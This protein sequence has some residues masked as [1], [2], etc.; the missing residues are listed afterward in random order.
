MKNLVVI[1]LVTP[2]Q[3]SQ[4]RE[5]HIGDHITITGTIFTARD[6]AHLRALKFARE[7]RPLPFPTQGNVLYHCGP[8]ARQLDSGWEI[9]SAGPTTSTRLEK[10]EAEFI[11]NFGIRVIIG[12]GGMLEQT[13][14]ALNQYGAI[15]CHFTGGAGVLAANFIETVEQ[16]EWLDLGIPE[17]V[18]VLKVKEFGPLLVA[19]DSFENSIFDKVQ[20]NV[21]NRKNIIFQKLNT[22][23]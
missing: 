2:I 14:D 19:I 23:E 11:R 10:F 20:K 4:I 12:K 22:S 1:N 6:E 18:W 7:N 5:L 21:L 3:E 8:I 9:I 16:V 13:Q 15:Y 17:A